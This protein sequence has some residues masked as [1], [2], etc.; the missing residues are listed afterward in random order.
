MDFYKYMLELLPPLYKTPNTLA[1]Y[2]VIASQ[3]NKLFEEIKKLPSKYVIDTCE[4]EDLLVL[5]NNLGIPKLETDSW[6]T[7]RQL[8]KINHYKL[9]TVPTHT[10]IVMLA[11]KV[12]GFEP[13][14]K[15]L[16]HNGDTEENDHGYYIAYDLPAEYPNKVLVELE[17]FIGAGIKIQRDFF[18]K[19]E[20]IT[21]YPA[22]YMFDDDQ[23]NIDCEVYSPI[24]TLDMQ[25]ENYFNESLIQYE[26]LS[27]N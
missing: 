4:N 5:G 25:L 3:M 24:K 20:G 14:L 1:R 19:L 7:Y 15:A 23:L 10:N 11:K 12:S 18:Y 8:I 26:I 16:W 27:I 13:Y 17:S 9:F 2:K 22:M 6:E 21:I